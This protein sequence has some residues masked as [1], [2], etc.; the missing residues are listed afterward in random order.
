M[1]LQFISSSGWS[2]GEEAIL[3]KRRR[4]GSEGKALQKLF[5]R[6]QDVR[7]KEKKSKSSAKYSFIVIM[8]ELAIQYLLTS[9]TEIKKRRL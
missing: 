4:V 3:M 5:C 9:Q 7:E 2:S 1:Q 8:V 6:S